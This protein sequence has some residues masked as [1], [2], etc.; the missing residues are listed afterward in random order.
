MIWKYNEL[1]DEFDENDS[2]IETIARE[3][4]GGDVI[5]ILKRL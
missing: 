1:Q 2:K 3:S 4:K 5:Y